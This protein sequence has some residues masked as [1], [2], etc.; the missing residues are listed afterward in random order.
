MKKGFLYFIAVF[1]LF[2][3]NK[4]EESSIFSYPK[5]WPK[6][7]YDFKANEL[8][9]EKVELGRALFYEGSLSKD[10]T[11][12]CSSCHSPYSSFT[13][14]DHDLSHGI[15]DRIGTRNSPVLVNLAWQKHF[16]M[17][18]AVHHL[19]AQAIAPIQNPLEMD[20]SLHLVVNKL[21]KQQL[22]REL[23][24][25]AWGDSIITGE[26]LL[27]SISSFM[28][29]LVSSNSKYDQVTANKASFTDQEKNG[30]KL[31]KKNCATCHSEPFFTN[32]NFERNHLSIDTSLNDYGRYGITKNPNDSLKFKVPTLRN[33]G[34]SKPY[35]HDGRF[36]TIREVV[37]FYSTNEKLNIELNDRERVD[38]TSFLL[39]LNDT[40]FVF[41]KDFSF[42]R[43]LF[44]K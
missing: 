20:D 27:K 10:G 12:S 40:S 35:M 19:D 34:F 39:T 32:H 24:F 11:I 37:K 16:M 44:L 33:I 9:P 15:E 18:G 4:E 7:E 43:H 17:D 31:F 14:T 38:L 41:N 42:P 30:Y 21:N 28:L 25:N 26:Y 2:S 22:Y 1:T 13:H 29:A 3:F 8:T 36:E 6:P 5:N 23:T